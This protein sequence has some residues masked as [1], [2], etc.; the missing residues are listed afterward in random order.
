MR[1]CAGKETL[2][3]DDGRGFRRQQLAP[4]LVAARENSENFHV[5]TGRKTQPTDQDSGLRG[6]IVKRYYV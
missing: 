3:V 2:I 4:S 5:L 1:G 6:I